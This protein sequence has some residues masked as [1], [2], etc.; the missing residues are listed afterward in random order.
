MNLMNSIPVP[1]P[2]RSEHA[3]PR[4]Y[5]GLEGVSWMSYPELVSLISQLPLEGLFVEV[6][7]ASGV[8]AALIAAARP[9]LTIHCLDTFFQ[10]KVNLSAAEKIADRKS[11]WEKNLLTH[12]NAHLMESTLGEYIDMYPLS[13]PSHVLID[14]DHSADGVTADL[15]DLSILTPDMFFAHDYGDATWTAVKPAVDEF[16]RVHGYQVVNLCHSL[17]TCQRMLF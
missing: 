14:G 15:K 10:P 4:S 2:S 13:R 11:H 8:T 12:P 9:Q 16:C 3:I 5:P 6:G 7:S 1:L 17:V